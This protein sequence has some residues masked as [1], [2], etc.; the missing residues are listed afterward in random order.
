MQE[1]KSNKSMMEE[2]KVEIE[3]LKIG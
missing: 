3:Q 2:M 1:N